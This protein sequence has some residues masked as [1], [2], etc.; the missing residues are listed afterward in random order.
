MLRVVRRGGAVGILNDQHARPPD[1]VTA[2]FFG[3]P[4]ATSSALARLVD[5][6]EAL[7]VPTS[8]IRVAPARW[9]LTYEPPLD[10]RALTGDERGV[11]RLTA[12]LNGILESMIRRHPEQWLWPHNRWRL[13]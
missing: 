4:A 9:R 3:R 10:V 13:D 6:T 7:V 5:R 1:A 2:P 8:A 11:E 12:R